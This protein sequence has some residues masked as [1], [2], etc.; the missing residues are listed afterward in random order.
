MPQFMKPQLT[1]SCHTSYSST[2]PF[3]Y[4]ETDD[5][6]IESP[7]GLFTLFSTTDCTD[8]SEDLTL[9]PGEEKVEGTSSH[10]PPEAPESLS[11]DEL[12]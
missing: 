8:L 7:E 6:G 4:S 5:F 11:A 1:G 12:L 2:L 9:G 3:S 10:L